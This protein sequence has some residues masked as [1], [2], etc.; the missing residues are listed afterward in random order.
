ADF[1]DDAAE[2]SLAAFAGFIAERRDAAH[3]GPDSC[4]RAAESVSRRPA[5][6]LVRG[7]GRLVG[8]AHPLW[9]IAR[10]AGAACVDGVGPAPRA[11]RIGTRRGPRVLTSH[12]GRDAGASGRA[13]A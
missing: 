13:L 10:L 7:D 3:P 2:R 8:P 9:V 11:S 1:H 6:G 5:P 12:A 4:V